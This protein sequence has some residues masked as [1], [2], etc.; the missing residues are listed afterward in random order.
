M[1]QPCRTLWNAGSVLSACVAAW[2]VA[3][4]AAA[5]LPV[6]DLSDRTP[7]TLIPPEFEGG[8]FN[9]IGAICDPRRR[10]VGA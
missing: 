7:E 4:P 3:T 1:T 5:Q 10:P 6:T 2:F 8:Y 9:R